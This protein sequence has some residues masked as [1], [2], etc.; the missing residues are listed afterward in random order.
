MI[1]SGIG[2]WTAGEIQHEGDQRH[3]QMAMKELGLNEDSREEG[4]PMTK[5]DD[6]RECEN[7]LDRS[8]AK[9]S[10]GLVARMHYL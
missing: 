1:L 5:G 7:E 3:V 10:K 4:V 2:T 6:N 9:Q 8:A